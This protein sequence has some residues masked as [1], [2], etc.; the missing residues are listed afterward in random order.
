MAQIQL[1]LS[2][3][4]E[5]VSKESVRTTIFQVLAALDFPVDAWQ[6]EGA[7]RS[8]V[9][10]QAHIAAI[11]S[12]S[13]AQI[14]RMV[15]LATAEGGFLDALVQS[16]FDL[17]R[18]EAV[19]SRFDVAMVNSGA[20]THPVTPGSVLLRATNGQMFQSNESATISANSTTVVEFVAQIPG[21][22]G[23]VQSQLLELVTPLAGVVA[24]YDGLLIEAGAD[25]ESDSK[26]RERA[27][28][29]WG[30]LR[31]EKIDLG[32]IA[33][34]R[35]A[36]A[37]VHG[38]SIDSD[39]PRGPGTV[40]V[41]LSSQNGTIGGGDL[42]AVQLVLD[43]ALFGTGTD[44]VA[45]LAVAAP[46]QTLDLSAN[47]Y[48][49]GALPDEVRSRLQDAWDAFVEEVPLGGFDLSPGPVN[50][51][52]RTQIVPELIRRAYPDGASPIVAIDV[53]DPTA[54]VD[55]TEHAK[56]VTGIVAFNVVSLA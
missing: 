20:A 2:D 21:E 35:G 54:D 29:Q 32:L 27:L 7:A 17:T 33:L 52:Q 36:A 4:Q 48:I 22:D 53:L 13:V 39:N 23:N 31:I 28:A 42:A 38:V 34:A 43:A 9:E 1:S 18:N 6:D 46:L 50:V 8:F 24:N 25:L 45:G 44:E 11:Q 26:L 49:R 14:A 16:H 55:V 56:V 47:V 3:L 37:G 51:I 12:Q 41:Y 40:D 30:L 10:V 15:F 19:A 5:P